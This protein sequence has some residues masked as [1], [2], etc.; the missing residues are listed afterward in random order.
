VPVVFI[1]DKLHENNKILSTSGDGVKLWVV[2]LSWCNDKLTDGFIPKLIAPRLIPLRRPETVI[3]ELLEAPLWHQ[4]G[5]VCRSCLELRV[6]KGVSEPVPTGGYLI[7]HYFHYQLP[8]YKVRD[9]RVQRSTAGL[10]GAR[11]RWGKSKPNGASHG[12]SHSGGYGESHSGSHAIDDAKG[13]N[14]NGGSHGENDAP[15][16]RTPYPRTQSDSSTGGAGGIDEP[17]LPD[18]PTPSSP[19]GPLGTAR[20]SSQARRGGLRPIGSAIEEL[21][22]ARGGG[23]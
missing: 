20:K 10:E 8:A 17:D 11:A 22:V 6:S 7:H 2:S 1:D 14:R 12:E 3:K 15:V 9:S 21:R 5:R 23:R 4:S 16:P 18:D 13:P 19:A